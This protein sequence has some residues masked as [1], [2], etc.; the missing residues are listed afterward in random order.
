[1]GV[2]A[3]EWWL[4]S[5]GRKECIWVCYECRGQRTLIV[6]EKEEEEDPA[7][8]WKDAAIREEQGELGEDSTGAEAS[9]RESSTG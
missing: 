7:K 6:K 3:S 5:P 8:E 1:M 9:R 4:K 2:S